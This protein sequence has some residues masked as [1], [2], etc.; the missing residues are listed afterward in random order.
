[1]QQLY[2]S[3]SISRWVMWHK[4]TSEYKTERKMKLQ[5]KGVDISENNGNVDFA[6]LK[7]AGIQFVMIRCGYG[8]DYENQEDKRFLENVRKAKAAGLP[9]GAWLYSYA[10]RPEDAI[11]EAKHA[12]RL[13]KKSGVPEYGCWYDMEDGDGYKARNGM[14]TNAALVDMCVTFC[15]WLKSAGYYT[16]IYASLSWFEN[17]FN[18]SKLDKYDKWVAQWS[19][20]CDYKKPYG[21]WQFTDKLIIGK[22][23]FDGNF[24]YKDYPKIINDMEDNDMT[25]EETLK[26][27]ASEIEKA[28]PTYH[29]LEQVPEYFRSEIKAMMEKGIIFGNSSTDLGLTKQEAKMAV[30][31]YRAMLK[32]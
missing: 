12:L 11:S 32:G 2:S 6:A 19:S 29:T 13:L 20:K 25:K 14:P 21:M 30:I 28:N 4:R 26:L 9:W 17:Q 15:E 5:V 31:T 3:L 8:G 18:S 24:A 10:L 7:K 1:M 27:I 22:K 16:G 23:A